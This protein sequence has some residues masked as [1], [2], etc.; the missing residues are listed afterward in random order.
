M[1]FSF[2]ESGTEKSVNVFDLTENGVENF[3]QI[4]ITGTRKLIRLQAVSVDDG[5]QL[6]EKN[7]EYF[8]E[9]TLILS[10][11][12]TSDEI[13]DL[14]SNENLVSLKVETPDRPQKERISNREKSSSELFSEFYTSRYGSEIPD[15]LLTLFLSLT[16]EE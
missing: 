1:Q 10:E 13:S 5:L 12:L 9:L 16:E 6:L 11:P 14:H 4:P 2:D 15:E 7:T 8:V 3:R